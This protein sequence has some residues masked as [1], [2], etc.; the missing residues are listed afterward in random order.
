MGEE[1][2]GRAVLSLSTDNSGLDKGLSDAE[3]KS[4]SWVSRVGGTL[5]KGLAIGAGVAIAA[6]AAL[7][8]VL[9]DSVKGA[10]DAELIQADLAATLLST[11]GAS[12]MT[13]ESI[14][15]LAASLQAVTPYE[16]DVIVSAENMLLTFTNIGKDVFPQATEAV[17][18]LATKMKG[19]LK[20]AAIQI[21]K[22]MND[23]IKGVTALTKAG[24]T[25]TD[26]QK[27][28]IKVMQ[29]AGNMAGAQG[30]I[31]KE[32]GTEFDGVARAAGSTFAG[33]MAILNNQI[34]GVK[35]ALGAALIP[36]LSDL[37]KK[38]GPDLIVMFEDLGGFLTTSLI[39][40]ISVM[41]DWLARAIGHVVGFGYTLVGVFS[42][43]KTA[44]GD[45]SLMITDTFGSIG[46][47]F[48]MTEDQ[49]TS[50]GMGVSNAFDWL[51][52]KL[53]ESI[54]FLRDRF[55][56][57]WAQIK[58]T[59]TDAWNNI[60][61]PLGDAYNWFKVTIPEGITFL[62]DRFNE[63]WPQIK[64]AVTD[65]WNAVK[66]KLGDAYNWLKI[67]VPEAIGFL[68]N[69]FNEYWPI[70]KQAV[71]DAWN[72]I[73]TPL[74]NF[75]DYLQT[76]I[77]GA[78]ANTKTALDTDATPAF[79]RMKTSVEGA[80]TAG[81]AMKTQWW[82]PI[83][84]LGPT[85]AGTINSVV[86]MFNSLHGVVDSVNNLFSKK[87]GGTIANF[88]GLNAFMESVGNSMLK[89][90]VGWFADAQRN[91]EGTTHG[92]QEFKK[93]LDSVTIPSWLQGG[94]GTAG[95]VFGV[96]H[97]AMGTSYAPGG[98]AMVGER[99]PELAALPRGS[100]VWPNGQGPSMG[101]D[102]FNITINA[103]GG[104][105]EAVRTATMDGLQAARAR[106]LR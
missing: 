40:A 48:G 35:D 99:G 82:D 58:Q 12:G 26:A 71:L 72:A 60:K 15:A 64:Q 18:N 51:R 63:Y 56:E 84:Q 70:I 31:M 13:A 14:N 55:N 81:V 106:G 19:D 92:L 78:A 80:T 91:I 33:Q 1:T 83:N 90:I 50:F 93:W 65:A 54:A 49:A 20:G 42:G 94:L 85:L 3:G 101:G 88:V 4:N 100:Q 69:R 66:E 46:Q 21:G 10:M 43:S 38:Y 39:P 59:V 52:T 6:G 8:A 11:K 22:A 24:V 67:N 27:A 95:S 68:K 28:Q 105:P 23:P 47:A 16:D 102:T 77:P 96:P 76:K 97:F 44:L 30:V 87:D 29:E 75:V 61:G 36:I 32:L 34:G 45:F 104:N 53:P 79:G 25:F 89:R 7:T 86:G 9:A 74:A 37:A 103:P 5:G 41:A 2:L 73:S 17:L 62:K 57:Y 98:L